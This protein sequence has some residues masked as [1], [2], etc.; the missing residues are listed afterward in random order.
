MSFAVAEPVG[1]IGLLEGT[2]SVTKLSGKRLFVAEGSNL[3]VGDVVVTGSNSKAMLAFTDGG[4]IALRPNTVFQIADYVYA[5]EQPAE[6][7]ALFQLLKGGLRTVT[8]LIGKRGNRDAYRLGNSTAT[9]GIRGTEY[10]AR[11]CANV[12]CDEP[13]AAPVKK[14]KPIIKQQPIAKVVLLKGL[15]SRE[16][17]EL[18]NEKT[19]LALESPLYV[20]DTVITNDATTIGLLFSDGTKVVVPSNSVFKLSS[21]QYAPDVAEKNSM[22]VQLLKGSARVV[23]GLIGKKNP[24]AVKYKTV[25][26]TIGIRGTK[27]DMSCIPSGSDKSGALSSS[28]VVMSAECDKALAVNLREGGVDM[29]SDNGLQGLEGTQSGY[30]DASDAQP[31][32]LSNTPKLFEDDVPLPESL[33][34]DTTKAFGGELS[35]PD[36]KGMFVTVIEGKVSVS[37]ATTGKGSLSLSAGESGFANASSGDVVLLSSTPDSVNY[38][39]FLKA[40]NFDSFS[41]GL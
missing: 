12:N 24:R 3:D 14:T 19:P 9:I 23:T 31:I 22:I 21:Y 39:P 35:N 17:I 41:C 16:A 37:Q 34:G 8:G 29:T 28:Q 10:I 5:K 20:G 11:V 30:A 13:G 4:K 15:A 2:V 38:D 7:G 25:T 27:F 36:D 32:L 33:D 1:Q 6:D 18:G 40:V 26:A